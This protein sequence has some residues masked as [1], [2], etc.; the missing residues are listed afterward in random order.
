MLSEPALSLT[1]LV[2]GAVTLGLAARVRTFEGLHRSWFLT[3][4]W[5]GIAAIAGFVHHGWVT[6]SDT[7]A[8]PS[9]AVVSMMVVLA[10]SYL[11]SATVHEVLGPGRRTAFWALRLASLGAY[12]ALA[13]AGRAGASSILLAESVTMV[14]ILALW[15]IALRRGNPLAKPVIA[16]FVVSGAAAIVQAMPPERRLV[17]L[18]P[19]SLYHLFQIPGLV[20]LYVAVARRHAGATR[21][22][23]LPAQA[24]TR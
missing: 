20:L 5:T 15:F 13:I 18:D 12:A 6:F 23:R 7:V 14:M 24:A 19:V 8:G 3:F 4:L 16:A 21:D 22:T 17:G 9:F 11:L 10:V 2:L 1:D